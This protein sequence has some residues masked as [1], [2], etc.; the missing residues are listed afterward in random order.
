MVS[1]M[2]NLKMNCCPNKKCQKELEKL[3][4]VDDVSTD[5]PKFS[6]AC[7]YCGFKLDPSK[8]QLFKRSEVLSEEKEEDTKATKLLVTRERP[9]GCPK[10]L[11]YLNGGVK[12]SP[13]LKECLD[14]F[15][16]T[17]CMLYDK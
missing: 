15:K 3:I 4:I 13:I 2:S 14:C 17:D 6:F 16:M 9:S 1:A 11:G 7:P 12:G 5:P 8:I 10:Y